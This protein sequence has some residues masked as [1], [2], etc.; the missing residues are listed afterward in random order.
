MRV[1]VH[2]IMM[3]PKIKGSLKERVEKGMAML[4]HPIDMMSPCNGPQLL[5]PLS[6]HHEVGS[7]VKCQTNSLT[8]SS[9]KVYD[10]CYIF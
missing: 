4:E 2:D 5:H 10:F 7:D 8:F 3:T 6:Q 1:C 9:M